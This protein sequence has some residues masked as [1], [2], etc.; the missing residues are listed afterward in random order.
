MK[1]FLEILQEEKSGDVHHVMT[2]GRMNPPTTGHLKLIDKVKDVAAKHKAGHT[3]V[4]S[5]SQDKNKNPLSS[6]EKIKHLKRY[7]PGTNFAASTKEHPTFLHHAS[8]LHKQGVTHL[9]MVVGS[10][11]VKEMKDKLHKYNGTHEGALH[12]FKKIHVHSAGHRDPDAEGTTGMSG[13]KMREHAKNKDI[14][15]FK[16]GVPSQV[17]DTHA[18]ELMHDTRKG[19]GLHESSYHGLFKAIF[20]T[21]GPGSGKDV[22]IRESIPH[23]GAI[24]INSVQAFDYLMDK[25]KLSESS[26]D[27]RREA[28]RSRLPL[29]IN[30]P[31]DDH[32]RM[33][34]IKEELEEL[35][36][37]TMLVFVDTTNEASK[38]RNERLTKMVSESVRKEKWELAQSSKEA[39]RQNFERF[40]N[41]DNSVALESIQEDITFTYQNVDDFL[42]GKSY[43]ET[44]NMWLENHGQLNIRDSINSLFK[45]NDYV[46]KTS[47]FV[48]RFNENKSI[49]LRKSVG[50]TA[51]GPGDIT[52]DNRA[53]DPNGANIKW[54]ANK[55]RGSYTFKTYSEENQPKLQIFPTPKESNFSKDKDKIRANKFGDK[56]LKDSRI[57]STD[58]VGSTW[59]TRTNGSGLTGG[60]GIGNPV[61]SESIDYN[62]QYPGNTG[63]PSGGSPNPLDS[64]YDNTFKKFRKNSKIKKEAI[65]NPGA[66][67]MGAT[68]GST[69]KEPMQNPKD[70]I[71]G[72]IEK[73]KKK[74]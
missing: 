31:A 33:I 30:G 27:Y 9:H 38:E 36:Y 65:D 43:T 41:F 26:K 21:G 54:D 23:Q 37:E 13:T 64:S 8:K 63:M 35:G 68:P 29:I 57:Q 59:N 16:Q 52:P 70:N 6:S 14:G 25:Q 4:T 5:H 19:M 22:V 42:G 50:A 55:K 62:F 49:K 11:R 18:K 66:N 48:H 32:Y 2:F 40:V 47:R 34:T 15:K 56:S 69:N 60:A 67:D 46:K 72:T 44:A 61:S 28:I 74:K 51:A 24:E 45:E 73:K 39:Y 1:S 53:G 58:G 20:V 17:S 71:G 10:D 12:N 7:S 3:V